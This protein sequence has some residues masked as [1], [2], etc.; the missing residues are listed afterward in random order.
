MKLARA[1][2]QR[3]P[4]KDRSFD[5]IL[6]LD[7]ISHKSIKKDTDVLKGIASL[8]KD[9]GHLLLADNAFRI[10]RSHHD[11]AYHVRERYTKKTLRKRLEA[12]GFSFVRGSYF[13]FFLFPPVFLIRL[14]ESLQRP[15]GPAPESDLKAVPPRLNSFL[16]SILRLEAALTRHLNLPW[17]SSVICLARKGHSPD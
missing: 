3:L 7:V 14:R 1:D 16:Y 10:L 4:F 5:L 13:N 11:A 8:L 15:K 17:G 9:G 2:V 6:L 12:A